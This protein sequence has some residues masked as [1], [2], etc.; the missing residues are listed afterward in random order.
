MKMTEKIEQEAKIEA[1]TESATPPP[2]LQKTDAKPEALKPE[3]ALQAELDALKKE[4]EALKQA[5]A[6][7]ND[8]EP[9]FT[10][11]AAPVKKNNPYVIA[12]SKPG[13]HL[14]VYSKK[15]PI[16]VY[17]YRKKALEGS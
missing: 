17:K 15:E 5:K 3:N 9:A 10:I 16:N 11:P 14:K 4:I 2:E 13:D 6:K 1:P 8:A 12:V 7:A